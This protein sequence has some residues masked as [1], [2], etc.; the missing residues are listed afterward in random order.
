MAST[1]QCHVT[2]TDLLT[3]NHLYCDVF[4]STDLIG[5]GDSP[6]MYRGQLQN[7]NDEL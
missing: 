1:K 4:Y 3:W 7:N 6:M 5:L 2:D